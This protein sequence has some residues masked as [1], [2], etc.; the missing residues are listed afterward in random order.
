MQQRKMRL[1]IAAHWVDADLVV[2]SGR[3]V[4]IQDF[5]NTTKKMFCQNR[6]S[7]FFPSKILRQDIEQGREIEG[8]EED[9]AP[10]VPLDKT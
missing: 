3:T 9:R 1:I 10:C 4:H 2:H 8:R 7:L 5:E 6:F